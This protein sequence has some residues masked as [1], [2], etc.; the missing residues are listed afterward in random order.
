LSATGSVL[1]SID[2]TALSQPLLKR[3]YAAISPEGTSTIK[4]ILFLAKVTV[5]PTEKREKSD[6]LQE[7]L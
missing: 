2:S 1:L 3:Y 6:M 7:L 4:I 5:K